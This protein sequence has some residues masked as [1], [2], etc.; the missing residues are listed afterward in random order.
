MDLE[1]LLSDAISC[2]SSGKI[3]RLFLVCYP[4]EHCLSDSPAGA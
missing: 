2:C 3:S 4:L 1:I